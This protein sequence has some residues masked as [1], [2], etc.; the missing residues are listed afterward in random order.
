MKKESTQN[1]SLAGKM[2][3]TIPSPKSTTVFNVKQ[4]ARS[5]TFDPKMPPG[6][7]NFGLN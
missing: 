3:T 4:F 2:K 1:L 7:G 5:Y 6:L